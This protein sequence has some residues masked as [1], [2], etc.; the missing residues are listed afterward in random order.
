ML[1]Q[2]KLSGVSLLVF[3]N[4]QDLTN[5]I[6]EEQIKEILELN[7]P[8]FKNRSVQIIPCSAFTGQG[9]VQGFDWI[10]GDISSRIFI[11]D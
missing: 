1:Q 7:T 3:A 4:K 9:L 11:A 10:V 8:V 2:D 6:N 5:S